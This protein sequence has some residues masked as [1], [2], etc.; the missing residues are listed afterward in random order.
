MGAVLKPIA[1]ASLLASLL[2]MVQSFPPFVSSSTRY[3]AADW[4]KATLGSS[5]MDNVTCVKEFSVSFEELVKTYND[6]IPVFKRSVPTS[7]DLY[8]EQG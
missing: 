4:I 2:S 7:S 1:S 6:T 5:Y 8:L 3:F